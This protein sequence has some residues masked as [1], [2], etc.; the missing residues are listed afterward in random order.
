MNLME[1]CVTKGGSTIVRSVDIGSRC[2]NGQSVV[3]EVASSYVS[4]LFMEFQYSSPPPGMNNECSCHC[5]KDPVIRDHNLSKNFVS[6]NQTIEV[7]PCLV[8]L[9]CKSDEY[10]STRKHSILLWE[11]STID[12][13]IPYEYNEAPES[14]ISSSAGLTVLLLVILPK[15]PAN[16]SKKN[17]AINTM[18]Q[19]ISPTMIE[20]PSIFTNIDLYLRKL[21]EILSTSDSR[22]RLPAEKIYG[23]LTAPN[24]SAYAGPCFLLRFRRKEGVSDDQVKSSLWNGKGK[25]FYSIINAEKIWEKKTNKEFNKHETVPKLYEEACNLVK[26]IQQSFMSFSS[27]Y[28]DL[29]NGEEIFRQSQIQLEFEASIAK[30]ISDQVKKD[31][32]KKSPT[33]A[34]NEKSQ[35]IKEIGVISERIAWMLRIRFLSLTPSLRKDQGRVGEESGDLGAG[36]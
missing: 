6:K 18:L 7:E 33:L 9:D 17:T 21:I 13:V 22:E 4:K 10:A 24:N 8:R 2:S 35:C 11:G 28:N 19:L 12:D 20:S 3:T 32:I 15:L 30:A 29:M 23:R 31:M 25:H 26:A 5:C 34:E 1:H 36:I 27:R 14:I 16:N